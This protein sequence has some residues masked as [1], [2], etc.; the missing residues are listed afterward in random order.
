MSDKDAAGIIDNLMADDATDLI[1]EMPANVVKRILANSSA[2]DRKTVNELLK[3]PE[4]SAGSIMTTEFVRLKEDMTVREAFALIRKVAIDKET[5]Y[6][7]ISFNI[8]MTFN[9]KHIST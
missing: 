9:R 6:I 5:I 2:E 7:Y 1:E 3:Y 4:D 8:F